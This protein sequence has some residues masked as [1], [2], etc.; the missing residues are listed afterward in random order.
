MR[1]L[2]EN[3]TLNA[4][5][6]CG[7]EIKVNDYYGYKIVAVIH[8]EYFWAAYMGLTDWSDDRVA[9]EGDKISY[10]AAKSLFPTIDATIPNYNS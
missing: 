5:N 9:R 1:Y 4:Y 7:D 3:G 8:S 10:N 2:N 6:I